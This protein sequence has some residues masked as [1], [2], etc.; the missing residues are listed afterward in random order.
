MEALRLALHNSGTLK[1]QAT[2]HAAVS[3]AARETGVD[4]DYLWRTAKRESGLNPTARASTSSAAGLFQFTSGTWMRMVERYG[5][6]YGLEISDQSSEQVLALRD[7]PVLSARMAG[8]LA[9]ENANILENQIGRKPT[10]QELYAAHFLGPAGAAKL[11]AAARENPSQS[12]TELFPREAAANQPIF[13]TSNGLDRSVAAV[14]AR[15]TGD[16]LSRV[17]GESVPKASTVQF[18]S[19]STPFTR[20]DKILSADEA[21]VRARSGQSLMAA[22]IGLQTDLDDQRDE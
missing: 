1:T 22:L 6:K 12:A 19:D 8:E 9:I 14:Y 5:D 11:I 17:E 21:I 3:Q 4:F 15:L 2:P 13:Q 7:D 20:L 10:P 16:T 18:V